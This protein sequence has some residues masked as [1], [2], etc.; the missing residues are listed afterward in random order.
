MKRNTQV[1]VDSRDFQMALDMYRMGLPE[2]EPN[3]VT[4]D[5]C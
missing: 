2:Q 1:R 5:C 4:R 3:E